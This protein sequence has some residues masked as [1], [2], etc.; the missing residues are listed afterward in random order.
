MS[1]NAYIY[2]YTR[3][4]SLF[5][6]PPCEIMLFSVFLYTN[7]L[8]YILILSA[9]DKLL[10][11]RVLGNYSFVNHRNLNYSVAHY[12]GVW[13]RGYYLVGKKAQGVLSHNA[14]LKLVK[15]IKGE[16]GVL[17]VWVEIDILCREHIVPHLK[18][19]LCCRSA[20]EIISHHTAKKSE[21]SAREDTFAALD[22]IGR[23]AYKYL[24]SVFSA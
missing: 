17:L 11:K 2:R 21:L 13:V 10:D 22:Y 20:I 24:D 3:A 8:V 23:N 12:I 1:T 15:G 6:L 4:D 16:V 18:S 19:A 9:G 7:P 14:G 5:S